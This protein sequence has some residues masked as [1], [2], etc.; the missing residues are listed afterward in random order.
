MST[1]NEYKR[2]TM[3]LCKSK[4]WS[5]VPIP[6]LWMLLTEEIGELASAI[7]RST[8]QFPDKKKIT[9]EGELMDVFSYLLQI[10]DYFNI[11]LDV[12]WEKYLDCKAREINLK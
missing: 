12:E 3:N 11:D 10:S 8:N 1:L 6:V 2:K 5:T 9:I 4:G 7:R